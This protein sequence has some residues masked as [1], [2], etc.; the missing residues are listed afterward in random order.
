MKTKFPIYIFFFLY[1]LLA[2]TNTTF[3]QYERPRSADNSNAKKANAYLSV[4]SGMYYKYGL[5]GVGL[6]MMVGE[7]VL[8]EYTFGLG[9]NA[10]KNG[11]NLVFNAGSNKKWRPT[12]GFVKASGVKGFETE[13]EV[14]IISTSATQKATAKIDRPPAYVLTP[15]LQR[16]FKF[17]N[18]STMAID[19]GIGLSLNNFEPNFSENAI[20]VDGF[21]VPVQEIKFSDLQKTLFQVNGPAGII[22]GLSYN[23]GLGLK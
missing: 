2:Q 10:F 3:G 20:V 21:I 15:S 4:G 18:G 13:V 14:V 19:L 1:L 9:A 12:I 6:G 22:V 8:A 16:I 5:L 17:R 23:F 11:V 7:D